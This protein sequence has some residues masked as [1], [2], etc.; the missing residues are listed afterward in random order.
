MFYSCHFPV[1]LILCQNNEYF[2]K[3]PL[4]QVTNVV[5][6]S[7]DEDVDIF[8]GVGGQVLS[9]T[10]EVDKNTHVAGKSRVKP[11]PPGEMS[12]AEEQ[13]AP[14]HYPSS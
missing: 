3:V 11:V 8:R 12:P 9:T 6:G 13:C 7:G 1:S 2:F 4:C 5:T 10:G 14:T